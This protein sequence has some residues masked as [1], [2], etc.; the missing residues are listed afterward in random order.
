MIARV[1]H[2]SP[3]AIIISERDKEDGL[4]VCFSIHHVTLYRCVR[5]DDDSAF[6]RWYLNNDLLNRP[7][8]TRHSRVPLLSHE[9]LDCH[10]PTVLAG[11]VY[12]PCV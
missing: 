10:G 6:A 4:L 9:D 7:A 3:G 12:R 5:P 2:Q 11:E 8:G 1:L